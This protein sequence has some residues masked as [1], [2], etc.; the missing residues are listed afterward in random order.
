MQALLYSQKSS[1][2]HL[3]KMK[4]GAFMG[5]PGTGKTRPCVELVREIDPEYVLY[6]APFQCIN[7][8]NYEESTR[9]EIEKWGGFKCDWDLVAIETIQSSDRAYLNAY[10]K[11]SAAKK[12]V[13]VVDES[14]KIKNGDAKRTKRMLA[15]SR[16]VEY[17]YI[18]NGTA[19]T[20]NLYDLK[21]QM[22]FLSPSI[23]NMP[24]SEFKN[25][26]V[27]WKKITIR[28]GGSYK[29]R[30]REWIIKYH[31]LHYLHELIR[32]YVFFAKLEL[33]VG[34]QEIPVYYELSEDER[35]EHVRIMDEILSDEWLRSQPNFFLKLTQSL[36][37]NYSRNEE[38]FAL[39]EDILKTFPDTLI[40]AKFVATQDELKRRFPKARI[41]SW[42]KNA[43]G[44]NMQ[45]Y[46][47]MLLFDQQFDYGLFDQIIK[48][49]FR[50]GQQCDCTVRRL[51]G[52]CG[53]ERLMWDNV[54][55]KADMLNEFKK[56]SN[57]QLKEV[58]L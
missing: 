26:F 39:T 22:D 48:R 50:T 15:L 29:T 27:E 55:K 20:R 7:A 25:T 24:D 9:Y 5:D 30:S 14:I 19:I 42:Q 33:T 17:K 43:Y 31:N 44:L 3:E 23:L 1:K 34:L 54:D 46:N 56:L 57:E 36:Q 12:G 58:L 11:L 2:A 52:N 35:A 47:Q 10:N 40:V 8:T 51:V 45:A 21:P 38:K 32:P 53:L 49:I 4:V 13:I 37:N 28:K 6:V 16:L 18:L 41:L